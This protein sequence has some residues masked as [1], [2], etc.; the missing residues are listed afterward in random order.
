MGCMISNICQRPTL[1]AA[2]LLALVLG[3]PLAALGRHELLEALLV[4][5]H[6]L[7]FLHLSVVLGQVLHRLL[8]HH[9]HL[10]LG[11]KSGN[12]ETSG[13]LLCNERSWRKN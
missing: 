5:D 2:H 1:P 12:T 11:L 9:A 10:G 4:G 3:T 7:Q 6:S 8:S 13:A